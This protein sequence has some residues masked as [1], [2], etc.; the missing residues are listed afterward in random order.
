MT[1]HLLVSKLEPLH[2]IIIQALQSSIPHRAIS[3]PNELYHDTRWE[4]LILHELSGISRNHSADMIVVC[5]PNPVRQHVDTDRVAA[6]PEGR[7]N[8][9]KNARETMSHR[10][11][12]ISE[13]VPLDDAF[14]IGTSLALMMIEHIRGEVKLHIVR[15][16]SLDAVA[17]DPGSLRHL[18]L[19]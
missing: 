15:I 11:L 8:M 5:L 12:P 16:R 18:D 19:V 7:P 4:D 10:T 14:N 1:P 9:V 2:K 13:L 17:D 3:K 6:R